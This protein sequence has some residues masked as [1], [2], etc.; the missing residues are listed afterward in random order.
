MGA[1]YVVT[2][3]CPGCGRVNDD[4]YYAPT[5]GFT[6]LECE[7][8]TEVDFAEYTGISYEDASNLE[9]IKRIVDP[10][11]EDS[12]NLR[13]DCGGEFLSFDYNAELE[14]TFVSLTGH[15][16]SLWDRLK[17]AWSILTGGKWCWREV[18]LGKEQM[19]TLKGWVDRVVMRYC[20]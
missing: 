18:V 15:Q 20:T 16:Y 2:V 11:P 5:C 7:C 1:R 13:C 10:Y 12:L 9:Q 17:F 6:S 8:G 14:F 3:T 4:V 19:L